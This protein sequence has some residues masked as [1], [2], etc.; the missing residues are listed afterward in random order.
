MITTEQTYTEQFARAV[1]A[2]TAS[3]QTMMTRIVEA[4]I[5]LAQATGSADD[6]GAVSV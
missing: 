2:L 4:A 1:G 6:Q 3:Q 5:I